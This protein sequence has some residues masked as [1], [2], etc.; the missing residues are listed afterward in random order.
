MWGIP[1]KIRSCPATVW[2]VSLLQVRH[3]EMVKR[4]TESECHLF[5]PSYNLRGMSSCME[6]AGEGCL[7]FFCVFLPRFL[8]MQG[9]L[10]IV[11]LLLFGNNSV[12]MDT[13]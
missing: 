2:G 12:I 5:L 11:G 10:I 7:L 4:G 6:E 3:R 13:C 8:F 9:D 1:V